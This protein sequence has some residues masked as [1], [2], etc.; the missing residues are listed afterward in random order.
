MLQAKKDKQ[1]YVSMGYTVQQL[2]DLIESHL[3]QL[4]NCVTE[5]NIMREII[6][7]QKT[8]NKK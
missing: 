7:Q 5:I 3:E 1:Y 2:E 4:R 8:L 6:A